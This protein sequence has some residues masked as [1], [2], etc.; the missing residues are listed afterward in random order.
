MLLNLG[1]HLHNI[2]ITHGDDGHQVGPVPTLVVF[3]QALYG[4]VFN[5]FREPYRGPVGVARGPE[6]Q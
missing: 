3:D 1:F 4:S 2:E 6:E 5:D